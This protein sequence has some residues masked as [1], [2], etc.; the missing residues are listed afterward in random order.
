MKIP[1]KFINHDFANFI[2]NVNV[3]EMNGIAVDKRPIE[4]C[5]QMP[6]LQSRFLPANLQVSESYGDMSYLT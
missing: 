6:P 5:S 2:L 4:N 1:D 3:L